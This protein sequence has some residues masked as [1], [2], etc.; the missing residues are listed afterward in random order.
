MARRKIRGPQTLCRNRTGGPGLLHRGPS[1]PEPILQ[2]YGLCPRPLLGRGRGPAPGTGFPAHHP[3]PTPG[4]GASRSLPVDPGRKRP[5]GLRQGP[6]PETP[7]IYPQAPLSPGPPRVRRQMEVLSPFGPPGIP[8]RALRDG[9]PYPS[10]AGGGRPGSGVSSLSRETKP[11]AGGGPG[12]P[13]RSHG[14]GG[15]RLRIDPPGCGPGPAGAGPLR[16]HRPGALGSLRG[17]GARSLSLVRTRPPGA[18]PA[19]TG[20]SQYHCQV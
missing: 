7:G 14:P 17:E 6:A 13:F 18:H 10:G 8:T 1:S 16:P 15:K 12:G 3:H 5:P 4:K 20:V 19:H 11:V 9:D 2:G